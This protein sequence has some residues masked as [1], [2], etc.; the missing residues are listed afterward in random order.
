MEKIIGVFGVLLM[1]TSCHADRFNAIDAILYDQQMQIDALDV[2]LEDRALQLQDNIDY[3]NDNLESLSDDLTSQIDSLNIYVSDQDEMI[4]EMI[5]D[6]IE[7]TNNDIDELNNRIDLEVELLNSSI[8]A[9]AS[10]VSSIQ[11][12][13]IELEGDLDLALGELSIEVTAL[14]QSLQ[15]ELL[16]TVADV[17]REYLSAEYNQILVQPNVTT[18]NNTTT[19]DTVEENAIC[20]SIDNLADNT[21]DYDGV[22]REDNETLEEFQ[23]RLRGIYGC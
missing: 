19:P 6:E 23:T 4:L 8:T 15:G 16:N 14:V 1:M 10:E 21:E 11:L 5:S 18:I 12:N 2:K 20:T 17:L 9:T 7:A 22:N 3:L 13:I